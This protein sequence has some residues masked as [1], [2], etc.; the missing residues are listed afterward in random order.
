ARKALGLPKNAPVSMQAI[1]QRRHELSAPYREVSRLSPEAAANLKKLKQV[2][3]DANAFMKHY[4]RQGD[5]NSLFKGQ[6]LSAEATA[7]EKALE[8]AAKAAGKPN[9]VDALRDAR[10]QIAKTFDVE[11]SLNVAT[12]NISAPTIGR[13]LDSGKPLSG[14]LAT[15]GKF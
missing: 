9:L 7:L 5:P 4:D 14:E 2:R 13:M 1:E 8:E 10:R 6:E 12:G 11:R 3:F 15:I